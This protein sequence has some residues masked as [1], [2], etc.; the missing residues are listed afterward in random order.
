MHLF[1][2][3]QFAAYVRDMTSKAISFMTPVGW[4][5]TALMHA[6]GLAELSRKMAKLYELDP[7]ST[8]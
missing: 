7:A 5:P 6:A 1:K 8:R 3:A 4:S 2:R